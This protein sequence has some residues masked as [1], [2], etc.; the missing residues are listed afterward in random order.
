MQEVVIY[1]DGACKGNPGPGGWGVI[2]SS[3]D[4]NREA[5]G[6]CDSTTNNQMEL[7]A[8]IEALKLLKKPCRVTLY[9]DSSYVVNGASK[10]MFGW[11]KNNW[12]IAKKKKIKNLPQWQQLDTLVQVHNISW[13]WV[14]GHSDNLGNN[15]ADKLAN[16]GVPKQSI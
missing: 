8:V 13:H 12:G 10:W 11:K 16:L 1:T 9:S 15:R 14:K 5:F 4:R 6:G 7:Q 2:L 3:G